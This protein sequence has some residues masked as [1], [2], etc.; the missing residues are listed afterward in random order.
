MFRGVSPPVAKGT[1]IARITQCFE[2]RVVTQRREV[3]LAFV[4]PGANTAR[5]EQTLGAKGLHRGPS[6]PSA[7]ERCKHQTKRLLDLGVRIEDHLFIL[8]VD[9]ADR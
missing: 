4:W 9:Q 3:D 2:D 8:G 7:F 6:R 5:K 1:C